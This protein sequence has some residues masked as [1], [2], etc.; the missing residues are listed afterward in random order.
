M[1]LVERQRLAGPA[2]HPRL[3]ALLSVNDAEELVVRCQ[4]LVEV[5]RFEEDDGPPVQLLGEAVKRH[6]VAEE[7]PGGHERQTR[8]R[9]GDDV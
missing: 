4:L 5:E 9:R 7:R 2:R 8:A 3:G 1:S 6:D